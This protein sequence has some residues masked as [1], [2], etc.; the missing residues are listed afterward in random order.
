M[1]AKI[2]TCAGFTGHW[3]TGTAAVVRADNPEIAAELLNKSL[4]HE[5]LEGNVKPE[6][7]EWFNELCDPV[8]ILCDG[9]Y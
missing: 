1:S 3:P 9:E 8:Q 5:G 6:D 4:E 2:Y 7:M